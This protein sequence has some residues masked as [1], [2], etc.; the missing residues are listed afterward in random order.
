M[1]AF[2]PTPTLITGMR[3]VKRERN[4]PPVLCGLGLVVVA[5]TVSPAV[6][7]QCAFSTERAFFPLSWWFCQSRTAGVSASF[8]KYFQLLYKHRLAC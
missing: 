3:M 6:A 7:A 4:L 1:S 5:F 8:F 2:Y